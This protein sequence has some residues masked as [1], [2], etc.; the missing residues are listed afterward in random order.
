MVFVDLDVTQ[1][2]GKRD[3]DLGDLIGDGH[4]DGFSRALT[5][6]QGHRDRNFE[7]L[8]FLLEAEDD[9]ALPLLA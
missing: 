4:D 1:P 3:A 8:P 6:P 9:I 2:A 7:E 5:V